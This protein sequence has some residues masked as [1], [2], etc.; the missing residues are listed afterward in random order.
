MI[1]S[2]WVAEVELAGGVRRALDK[3]DHLATQ[4]ARFKEFGWREFGLSP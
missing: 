3:M 4:R 2:E 1:H